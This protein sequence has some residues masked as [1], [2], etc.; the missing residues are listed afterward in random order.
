MTDDPAGLAW[1]NGL[2]RD[3]AVRE[4]AAVCAAPAWADAVADGRPYRSVADALECSDAAAAA[5]TVA[6]LADALAGH[7]RIGQRPAGQRRA[8]RLAGEERSA[9][10]SRQEQA[11]V[12]DGDPAT[13]DA[14]AAA[15]AAYEGRFGHIYLVCASGR[16]AAEL[17]AVLRER[18]DNDDETEWQVVRTEI[19]KINQIRLRTL[20]AGRA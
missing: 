16:T 4:L 15:N 5:L 19:A 1:F 14:L 3:A 10:W 7:P 18:L 20:L 9:G 13:I 2:A 12:H 6:D 11:R 8:G 17:L